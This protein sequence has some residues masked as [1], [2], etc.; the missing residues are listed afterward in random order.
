[1]PFLGAVAEC[2]GTAADWLVVLRG[3][4]PFLVLEVA[5]RYADAN[6]MPRATARREAFCTLYRGE[7]RK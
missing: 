1:M 7:S 3:K 2:G 5:D 4:R 6:G